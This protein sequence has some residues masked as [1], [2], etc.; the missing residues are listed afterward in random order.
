MKKIIHSS[1]VNS[2]RHLSITFILSTVALIAIVLVNLQ[3]TSSIPSI[4]G[5]KSFLTKLGILLWCIS[6][7]VSFFAASLLF[8]IGQKE[9]G[10]FF[11]YSALLTT[12]ILF[13][14]FFELHERFLPVYLNIEEKELYLILAILASTLVIKFRQLILQTNYIVMLLALGFMAISVAADGVL[15]PIEITYVAL[16]ILIISVIYL[17]LFH[18]SILKEFLPLIMMVVIGLYTTYIILKTNSEYSEYLFEEGAKW[19]GI[20]SWCSYFIHTAY[21]LVIKSYTNR[22]TQ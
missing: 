18:S 8:N 12:Y 13:D 4:I 7:T 2:K 1:L 6:A 22:V 11:F 14:D 9:A 21:Q 15:N 16:T 17:G 5:E 3:F 19:L 10:K 20:T